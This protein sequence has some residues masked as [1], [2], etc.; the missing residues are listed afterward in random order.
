[1]NSKNHS[2]IDSSSSIIRAINKS[3]KNF[4]DVIKLP[5]TVRHF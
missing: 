2:V 4:N 1:M 5:G 3:L